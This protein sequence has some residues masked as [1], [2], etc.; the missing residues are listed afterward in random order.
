MSNTHEPLEQSGRHIE[1]EE[2]DDD[3]ATAL[4]NTPKTK[5]DKINLFV[6]HSFGGEMKF[7]IHSIS[8]HGLCNIGFC[9]FSS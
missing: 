9:K 7:V 2:Y 4:P 5:T 6:I 1:D 3:F 8:L